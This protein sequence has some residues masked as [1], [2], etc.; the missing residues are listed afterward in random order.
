[1]PSDL[2][3]LTAL[4]NGGREPKANDE[5]PAAAAAPPVL[6][7]RPGEPVPDGPVANRRRIRQLG[8][9]AGLVP[10]IIAAGLGALLLWGSNT[11]WRGVPGFG[12]LVAAMPV[13]PITGVPAEG[14]NTRYLIAVVTSAVMWLVI[15]SVA[16]RRATKLP[17]A[18]WEDWVE[19]YRRLAIGAAAGGVAALVLSWLA[20]DLGIA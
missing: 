1:M 17:V 14:G 18:T 12:L 8:A 9:L 19:E 6:A 20:V 10:P 2:S 5:P 4:E 13:L 7:Y 15:G 16:A 3:R 11:G